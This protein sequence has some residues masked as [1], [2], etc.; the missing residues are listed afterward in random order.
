MQ[1]IVLCRLDDALIRLRRPWQHHQSSGCW[2][3]R[4]VFHKDGN[5]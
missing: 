5:Q 1:V 4:T 2:S 3:N